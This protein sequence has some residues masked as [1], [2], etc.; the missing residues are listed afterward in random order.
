M[1]ENAQY[2]TILTERIGMVER[3]TLDRPGKRNA[4]S[5]ELQNE[6]IAAVGAAESSDE[7]RCIVIRGQ[8]RRFAPVMT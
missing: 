8:A 1:A 4:L 5:L 6:L 2:S 3:I 7:V